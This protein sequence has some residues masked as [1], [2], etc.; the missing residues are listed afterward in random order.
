MKKSVFETIN[1][2]FS[3][4]RNAAAGS[5]RQLNANITKERQL[6]YFLSSHR[7]IRDIAFK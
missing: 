1:D 4:P 6:I 5:L 7:I 2:Q 3:N